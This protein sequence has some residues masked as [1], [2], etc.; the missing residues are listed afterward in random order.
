MSLYYTAVISSMVRQY[1][2]TK[3]ERTYN[4]KS[5]SNHIMKNNFIC[6]VKSLKEPIQ[7]T[8]ICFDFDV[9]KIW[10]KQKSTTFGRTMTPYTYLLAIQKIVYNYCM[11]GGLT[12]RQPIKLQ[13]RNFRLTPSYLIHSFLY[14]YKKQV[15]KLPVYGK[16][17]ITITYSASHKLLQVTYSANHKLLQP[18]WS[19]SLK[20]LQVTYSA[21]HKWLQTTYSLSH[22]FMRPTFITEL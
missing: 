19:A 16:P 12:R 4:E 20:L 9:L 10:S 18:T 22:N 15:P 11:H 13:Y 21:N 8:I 14:R 1:Q 2:K 17:Q 7:A 3:T 6:Q 5:F